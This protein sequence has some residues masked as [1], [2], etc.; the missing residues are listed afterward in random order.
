MGVL[1]NGIPYLT[2]RGLSEMSGAARSTIQELS[3]EWEEAH[4]SGV[5]PRGRITFFRDHLARNGF[6]EPRLFM[7]IVKDSSPHYAYP[8]VVCTAIIEYF[9]FEAQ[10][11]NDTA[12][13]SFRNLATFGLQSF[14]YKALGYSKPDKWKYHHDR[15]SI[16]QGAAPD[17]HF[18]IFNEVSGMVVDLINADLV[19]ND[20]TVPDI[21]VG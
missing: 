9:A 13:R 12:V 7:E 17:D 8:D 10:R 15:V 20:K 21:S 3:Q 18:I 6:N 16:L 2:Q 5:F 19:V 11:I 4:R 14:I 1:E